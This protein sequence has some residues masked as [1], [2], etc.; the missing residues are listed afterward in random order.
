M[1]KFGG[2]SGSDVTTPLGFR[3]ADVRN[4]IGTGS[5]RVAGIVN[6]SALSNT[7]TFSPGG[8]FEYP[9]DWKTGTPLPSHLNEEL[10]TRRNQLYYANA[11]EGTLISHFHTVK[12]LY[13]VTL[14]VYSFQTEIFEA[15]TAPV[16]EGE[17]AGASGAGAAAQSSS[18]ARGEGFTRSEAIQMQ[19]R[20]GLYSAAAIAA[21]AV[22]RETQAFSGRQA[23]NAQATPAVPVIQRALAFDFASGQWVLATTTIVRGTYTPPA[24]RATPAAT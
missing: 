21:D 8:E 13:D 11:P 24:P 16:F 2:W 1:K 12:S 10:Y 6:A 5:G 22:V 17:Q 3:F 15:R 19:T 9:T 23:A 18:N 4:K 14:P 7:P 20:T